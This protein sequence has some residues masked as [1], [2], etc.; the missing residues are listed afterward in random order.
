MSIALPILMLLY[1]TSLMWRR[2]LVMSYTTSQPPLP[3]ESLPKDT[4]TIAQA[5]LSGDPLLESRLEANLK[6]LSQQRFLWLI[7][8]DDSEGRRIA[9]KL[10]RP[11]IQTVLCTACPDTVNPKLWKLQTA[12]R[13]V[14]TPFLAVIDDDT[15]LSATSAAAL[16]EAAKTST[17]ATG[18]P[19][20]LDNDTIPSR[21][22]AQFVNNNSLFTYLGTSRL[23]PPFTLNGMGYVMRSEEL[24]RI[25]HFQPILHELTDDLALATHILS[26]G[27]SIHQSQAPLQVQTDV[28]N[29]RHYMQMMH[30][31]YVFTLLLLKRQSMPVQ[32]LIFVLHGLAPFCLLAIVGA[33]LASWSLQASLL[34]FA[35]LLARGFIIA[36]LNKRFFGALC[37]YSNAESLIS[38][39]IQP[40]HLIHALVSRTI[41][42]RTRYYRVVDTHDF[43]AV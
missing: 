30:R 11:Q 41:R 38:E 40:L 8:E 19:C 2:W 16:V 9:E 32:A 7:D 35:T 4:L 26:I 31:W 10:K 21:L 5:I 28:R 20:Y 12:S 14:A 22:L 33:A 27:G 36:T 13:L 25:Q 37:H 23:L 39:I 3:K 17:V 18:C 43:K 6:S 34:F 29:M 24:E 42:W 1:L 15:T